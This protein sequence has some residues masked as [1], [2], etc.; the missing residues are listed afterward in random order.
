MTDRLGIYGMPFDVVV[1]RAVRIMS[2]TGI[3]QA[4]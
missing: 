2:M 1:R 3:E 4:I